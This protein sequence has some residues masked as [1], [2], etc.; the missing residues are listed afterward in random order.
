MRT[1]FG[2]RRKRGLKEKRKSEK[3]EWEVEGTREVEKWGNRKTKKMQV[4]EAA[5][6]YFI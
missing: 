2:L 5:L 3:Q 1:I 4:I 6:T